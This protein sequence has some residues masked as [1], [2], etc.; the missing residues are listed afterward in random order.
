LA[1]PDLPLDAAQRLE[2]ENA[3]QRRDYKRAET[4]LVEEAERDPKSVR[5]ARLLVIAGGIF[6]LDGQYLN[7]AIAWKKAEAI[8]PLDERS[9][10]TLAMAYIRLNRRN[11]ARI[12]LEKLATVQPRNP[13]YLYWLARLDYDGR[14]YAAAITK[15]QKVIELD[16]KMARAYDGLGLCHDYIGRVDDA[17]NDYHRAIELNRQQLKPSPWPLVDLAVALIEKNQLAEAEK[18]L[19]EAIGYDPRLPH[20]YYELG[21]VLDG[22]DRH[23]EAVEA[24]KQAIALDAAYPEPHYLLGRIYRRQGDNRLAKTEI[25]RFLELKK[26]AEAQPPA[27]L[28]P[29]PNQP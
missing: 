13:L 25:D 17:I 10:F 20:A 3:I 1:G 19:R 14:I 15:F 16:P 24:L 26:A 22:L 12:E 8:A 7:S 2:L 6:F 11:W 21:H 5:A 29:L 27:K 23:Q 9:R 28:H 18:S 4:L